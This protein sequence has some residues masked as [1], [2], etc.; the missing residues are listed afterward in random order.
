MFFRRQRHLPT[1]GSRPINHPDMLV[2]FIDAM[3]VEKARRDQSAC[4]WSSGGGTFP[5]QFH[6]QATFLLR[7]AQGRNLRVFIQFD[8]PTER[9]PLAKFAM[10]DDQNLPVV[11][12]KNRH[13]EINFL[14]YMRHDDG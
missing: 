13:R 12:D 1:L 3:D 4:S 8:M 14:V 10:M 7:L 6:V 11:D 2:R 9:Q 5:E